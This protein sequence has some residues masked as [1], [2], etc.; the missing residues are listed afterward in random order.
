MYK[1]KDA[2]PES[3]NAATQQLRALSGGMPSLLT[4][5]VGANVASSA[6]N[7]DVGLIATLQTALACSHIA[8][9]DSEQ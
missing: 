3:R 2:S 4:L 5:D 6:H 9:I 1:L 7:Y 8:A